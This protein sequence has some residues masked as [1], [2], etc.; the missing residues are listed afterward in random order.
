MKISIS[1][2]V[3]SLKCWECTTGTCVFDE[4]NTN[5]GVEKTCKGINPVCAKQEFGNT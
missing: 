2:L 1:V 3:L 5:F 4:S